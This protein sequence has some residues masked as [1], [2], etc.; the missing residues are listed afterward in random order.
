M[1]IS[2]N[3][4]RYKATVSGN[5]A[6]SMVAGRKLTFTSAIM[7]KLG[8]SKASIGKK[9]LGEDGIAIELDTETK[10]L[11]LYKVPKSEGYT[12]G[13]SF[14]KPETYCAEICNAVLKLIG[15]KL[16]NAGT[17]NFPS[18]Y[19]DVFEEDNNIC[20]VVK[21]DKYTANPGVF[22]ENEGGKK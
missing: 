3:K 22:A 10:E 21:I 15:K 7:E 1:A 13:G 16:T 8:I 9:S 2:K 17:V 11:V 14:S 19:D 5:A 18:M 6:V 4:Q 12:V 20:I